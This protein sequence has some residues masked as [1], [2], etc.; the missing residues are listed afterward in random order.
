MNTEEININAQ[1]CLLGI[2][3]NL[4]KPMTVEIKAATDASREKI[5]L[6]QKKNSVLLWFLLIG[7]IINFCG[8]VVI[9]CLLVK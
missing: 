3:D 9:L 7:T 6:N 5:L 2:R 4:L 8:I 1:K